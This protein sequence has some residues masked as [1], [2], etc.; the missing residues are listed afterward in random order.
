MKKKE[1]NEI[2]INGTKRKKRIID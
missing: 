2:D 1:R